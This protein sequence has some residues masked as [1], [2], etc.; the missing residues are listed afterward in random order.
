MQNHS[1]RKLLANLNYREEEEYKKCLFLVLFF[2]IMAIILYSGTV[3]SGKSLHCS[4][5]IRDN[6]RNNK[7]VISTC[8]IDTSYCFMN[9]LQEL[10][11]NLSKGK[12]H[13]WQHDEREKNFKYID[14]LEVT[15]QYLYEHAARYHVEGKEHQ[16]YLYLDECV[17]IF[18]PTCSTMQDTK[19]WEEWQTFFRVSRQIGYEVILIPQQATLICKKVVACCELDVRHYNY[20]YK[21]TLGFFLSLFLGGLFCAATFWRGEKRQCVEQKMYRYKRLYGAMYNSYTLFDDTLKVYKIK[22]KK[23]DEERNRLLTQLCC[24]LTAKIEMEK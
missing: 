14:I 16:T 4:R 22:I 12:I 17:A 3:G 9:K 11:F 18:S 6:L 19:R 8:K 10:I 7:Y 1:S 5:E 2:H 24:I 23:E 13:L 15:P 21:G 20:K